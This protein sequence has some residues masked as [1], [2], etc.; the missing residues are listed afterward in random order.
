MDSLFTTVQ[1]FWPLV[2]GAA[3]VVGLV[4]ADDLRRRSIEA[5]RGLLASF[6]IASTSSL[7]IVGGGIGLTA[8][9][10]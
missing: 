10:L 2:I 5:R 3:G 4:I 8:L 6:A 7:A 1:H 9:Y